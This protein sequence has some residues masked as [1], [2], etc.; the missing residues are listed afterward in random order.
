M[1]YFQ[2]LRQENSFPFTFTSEKI[3][4]YENIFHINGTCSNEFIDVLIWIENT[5]IRK[6]LENLNFCKAYSSFQELSEKYLK[7]TIR[8]YYD[9]IDDKDFNLTVNDDYVKYIILEEKLTSHK[10]IKDISE[11]INQEMR[12]F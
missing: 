12:Y 10:L 7:D 2:F 5:R 11:K 4:H 1:D 8:E 9:S 3:I 6:D